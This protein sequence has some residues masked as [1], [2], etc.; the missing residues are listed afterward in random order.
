MLWNRRS[1][2]ESNGHRTQLPERLHIPYP[3]F[4]Y[5]WYSLC[6]ADC[7]KGK[8]YFKLV[9][10]KFFNGFSCTISFLSYARVYSRLLSLFFVYREFV[11][12]ILAVFFLI[13]DA[14]NLKLEK[15]PV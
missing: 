7:Q 13:L 4:N 1:A 3:A 11:I 9:M 2:F 6:N 5:Q 15:S 12:T 10:Q 14:E 8:I